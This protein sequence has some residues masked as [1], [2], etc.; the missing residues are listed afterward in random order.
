MSC[1]ESQLGHIRL[2]AVLSFLS[3]SV[4][5]R[6]G[7]AGS[8]QVQSEQETLSTT[9]GNTTD[10]TGVQRTPGIEFIG[11]E[12]RIINIP[13]KLLMILMPAKQQKFKLTEAMSDILSKFALPLT[14]IFF[15]FFLKYF[16]GWE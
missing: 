14:E 3:L 1:V 4:R 13:D 10:T 6:A 5:S 11:R 15:H 9:L 16:W 12:A 7:W 2:Q 8:V